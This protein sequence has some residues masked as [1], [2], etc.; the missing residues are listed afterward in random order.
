MIYLDHHA[1]CPP[2]PEVLAAVAHARAHAWA[3]PSSRH[4]AGRAARALL[5]GARRDVSAAIGAE[6]VDVVLTGGGTEAVG[7]AVLGV[8]RGVGR[9]VT[10]GAAHPALAASVARLAEGGAEVRRLSVLAGRPASSDELRA[11]LAP[12]AVLA[13]PWVCHETGVVSPVSSWAHVC[14]EVG[15]RMVVDATQALGKIPLAVNAVGAEAIAIASSKVGGPAGAGALWLRPGVDVE[16]LFA[17]GPQ[18]RGR[19]PGTPDV[20]AQAGFAAACRAIPDRLAAMERLEGLR[21][22]LEAGVVRLGGAVAGLAGRRVPTVVTASFRGRRGDELVAALDLE[23]VCA[24]SGAACSSGL[25][26][27][28]AILAAMYPTEPWRARSSLR[29]SLGRDTSDADVDGALVALERVLERGRGDL[30]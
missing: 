28:S 16:P 4:A 30:Q 21:Q 5:E 26:E 19:R 24:S 8:G 6:P 3:N 29:L 2:T 13:V 9:V 14:R 7:L 23:G 12:G 22:R 11:A 27:P 18:E 25:D 20:A 15:A 17:G 10:T 1:A